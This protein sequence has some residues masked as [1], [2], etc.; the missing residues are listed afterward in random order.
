MANSQRS[1]KPPEETPACTKCGAHL[2]T[3]GYPLWCVACR[4]DYARD[5]Q[6]KLIERAQRHGF[7]S[8]C[9]AMRHAIAEKFR[10]FGRAHF[11][12]QEVAAIVQTSV[13]QPGAAT[14]QPAGSDREDDG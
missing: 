8:G 1:G 13:A 7:G 4:T 6:T 2:D 10:A 12:A 11:S 5:R 14:A 3:T 9:A